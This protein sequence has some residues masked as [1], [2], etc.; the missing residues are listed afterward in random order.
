M[1]LNDTNLKGILVVKLLLSKNTEG[2]D[3][4]KDSFYYWSVLNLLS[5]LAG[6]TQLDILIVTHQVAKFSSN[7]KACHDTAIKRIG[8][9][10]LSSLDKWLIYKPDAS[11]GLEVHVDADFAGGFDKM[12]AKDPA[13]VYSR[14][15]YII[16]YAGC[17]I[18]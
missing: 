15:V 13:S 2:K 6:C 5:Y 11:K 7:P 16:K 9:Y 10:M 8:N 1:D 18:I 12:N 14:T 3:R 17:P 4:N